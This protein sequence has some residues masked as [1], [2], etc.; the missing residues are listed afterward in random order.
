MLRTQGVR[1]WSG[2]ADR[3]G[4]SAPKSRARS[5]SASRRSMRDKSSYIRTP[6]VAG[7]TMAHSHRPMASPTK[8]ARSSS[9][10]TLHSAVG[11][12]AAK[13][14]AS[15]GPRSKPA[16]GSGSSS[17]ACRAPSPTP[18]SSATITSS[19]APPS[20]PGPDKQVAVALAPVRSSPAYAIPLQT[21]PAG[22]GCGIHSGTVARPT[23]CSTA[24][25]PIWVRTR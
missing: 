12:E 22:N 2:N 3:R 14:F 11:C 9:A 25:G 16:P 24:S 19:A 6:A 7:Q 10:G 20:G 18:G 21:Q 4:E 17:P 23:T 13:T 1:R 8:I 15:G 5:A